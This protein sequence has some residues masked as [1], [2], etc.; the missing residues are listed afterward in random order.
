MATS[1]RDGPTVDREELKAILTAKGKEAYWT[2]IKAAAGGLTVLLHEYEGGAFGATPPDATKYEAALD[3]LAGS[4]HSAMGGS[5]PALTAVKGGC[6]L[7]VQACRARASV[8]ETAAMAAAGATAKGGTTTDVA[9]LVRT[10]NAQRNGAHFGD[11]QMCAHS[12]IKSLHDAL[13]GEPRSLAALGDLLKVPSLS[14]ERAFKAAKARDEDDGV[15]ISGKAAGVG[16]GAKRDRGKI[17]TKDVEARGAIVLRGCFY[18]SSYTPAAAA[19]G[20]PA[21]GLSGYGEVTGTGGAKQREM[22]LGELEQ[23]L[24]QWK[25]LCFASPTGAHARLTFEKLWGKATEYV[26]SSVGRS[27]LLAYAL[28]SA[29]E[30]VREHPVPA[31]APRDGPR[32]PWPNGGDPPKGKGKGKGPKGK[33]KGP[34]GKANGPIYGHDTGRGRCR[35]FDRGGDGPNGCHRGIALCRFDHLPRAV[36]PAGGGAGDAAGAGAAAAAPDGEE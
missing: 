6:N 29:F 3:K 21:L 36:V 5:A 28:E 18:A 16:R 8:T 35:D 13:T 1:R 2:G 19:D 17:N 27:R 7:I 22:N 26:S 20:G 25:Q 34:K 24:E 11:D 31:K 30:H 23:F 15:T 32:E 9:K 10:G 33:G 14:E 12:L 4:V